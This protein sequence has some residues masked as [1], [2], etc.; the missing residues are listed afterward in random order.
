MSES[1]FQPGTRVRHEFHGEGVA[2]ATPDPTGD[3][4]WTTITGGH[5]LSRTADLT[6]IPDE[7]EVLVR[8]PRAEAE[9]AMV[10]GRA[11]PGLAH[12]DGW[13]EPMF[14]VGARAVAALLAQEDDR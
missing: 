7:V 5:Y 2:L 13:H 4:P 9:E 8:V 14:K 1:V 12:P 3:V 10:S 11:K 6:V